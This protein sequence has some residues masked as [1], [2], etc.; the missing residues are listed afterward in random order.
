[1]FESDNRFSMANNIDKIYVL[2][3]GRFNGIDRKQKQTTY[4]NTATGAGM[5]KQW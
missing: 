2:V 5:I 3:L 1:M 4:K